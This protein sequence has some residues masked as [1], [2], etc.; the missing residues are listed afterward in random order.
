MSESNTTRVYCTVSRCSRWANINNDGLCPKHVALAE[1]DKGEVIYKCLEC[2]MECKKDQPAVLCDRC[3]TWAHITCINMPRDIYDMIFKEGNIAGMR[4]FCPKCDE[5][6]TEA[7]EKYATIEQDTISLKKDMIDVKEQ[8]ADI[9][10]SIKTTVGDTINNAMDDR[11]EI[12]K[13]KMNLIVF[14]LPE[15]DAKKPENEKNSVEHT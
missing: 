4:Y 7:M 13:R 14:G 10:K 15:I 11:R 12:E 9:K 5:K 3:D 2:D 6:V 8:L 1:K